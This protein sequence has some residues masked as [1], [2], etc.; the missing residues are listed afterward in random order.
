MDATGGP[1]GGRAGSFPET[2]MGSPKPFMDAM[3]WAEAAS[4]VR[5][6]CGHT[7]MLSKTLKKS[8]QDIQKMPS[9][10]EKSGRNRSL[11]C[12]YSSHS[13]LPSLQLPFQTWSF[14]QGF[15][16]HK[17]R[18][19]SVSMTCR[20][21]YEWPSTKP[22]LRLNSLGPVA[23][24]IEQDMRWFARSCWSMSRN[25]ASS[26][27]SSGRPLLWNFVSRGDSV[28]LRHTSSDLSHMNVPRSPVSARNATA[29][30]PP[31]SFE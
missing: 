30:L 20:S 9:S 28:H 3:A 29:A 16:R 27:F 18:W 19:R 23:L 10:P 11:S 8:S 15:R 4:P 2:R 5:M 1:F 26:F 22:S 13:R 7:T 14:P 25:N 21:E 31:S 6:L 12:G 17:S 24:R